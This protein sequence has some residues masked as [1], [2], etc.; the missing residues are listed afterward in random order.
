MHQ[1]PELSELPNYEI[2]VHMVRRNTNGRVARVFTTVL[3]AV[4]AE[5]ATRGGLEFGHAIGEAS[6]WEWKF[7]GLDGGDVTVARLD[8]VHE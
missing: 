4:D 1:S 6:R 7:A 8:T 5:S 2:M 3:P